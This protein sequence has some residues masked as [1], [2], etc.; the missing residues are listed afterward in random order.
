MRDQRLWTWHVLAGLIILV[1]LGLH[2]AIMHLD[3]LLGE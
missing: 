1:F 3:V 2:M